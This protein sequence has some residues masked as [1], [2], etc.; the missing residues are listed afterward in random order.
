MTKKVLSIGNSLSTMIRF[1]GH[2]Y[3]R[4]SSDYHFTFFVPIDN[5]K[6]IS[7]NY[8]VINNYL[9]DGR[10]VSLIRICIFFKSLRSELNGDYDYIII[11]G[12]GMSFITSLYLLFFPHKDKKIVFFFT[13]L[14][15]IFLRPRYFLLKLIFKNI[16]LRLVPDKVIVLNDDDKIYL[17]RIWSLKNVKVT[18]INGESV[19][20]HMRLSDASRSTETNRLVFVSRPV[21][22]KGCLEFRRLVEVLR[23]MQ[24]KNPI[25]VYGFD[26]NNMGELDEEYFSFLEERK[27]AFKGKVKA[28]EDNLRSNDIV[29]IISAREGA[30]RVLLE[31]LHLELLFLGSEVPGI[32]NFVPRKL[33]SRLLTNY[34]NAE[35]SAKK[36]K[37]L[38]ERSDKEVKN[39]K[40]EYRLD[41]RFASAADVEKFYRVEVLS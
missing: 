21:L 13:G 19:P 20:D 3:S 34:S 12:V 7:E 4:L 1:R 41:R 25:S 40:E 31:C 14:G 24:I 2:I 9:N 37:W 38:T 17:K 28:L 22:D 18:C 39:I 35:L 26:R 11:Y 23:S 33:G 30:N 8:K 27:V 5:Q 32:T 10:N 6:N 29:L 36:I 15:A 16:L